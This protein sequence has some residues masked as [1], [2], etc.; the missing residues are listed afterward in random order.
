MFYLHC[1]CLK[2]PLLEKE[3]GLPRVSTYLFDVV[4]GVY[5]KSILKRFKVLGLYNA[6]HRKYA[7]KL[8]KQL[9]I[10]R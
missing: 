3:K 7:Y 10:K 1:G 2:E 5:K 8:L 9:L 4:R 6:T